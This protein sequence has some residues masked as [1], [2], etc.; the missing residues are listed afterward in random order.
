V[1]RL[2]LLEVNVIS[3]RLLFVIVTLLVSLPVLAQ[4]ETI[5]IGIVDADR[6]VRESVEMQKVYKDMQ[7]LVDKKQNELQKKQEE[8]AQM[9]DKYKTQASVLSGDARAQLEE[10]IRKGYT[11]LDKFREDSKIE[12]QTKESAA[13][14]EMEKKV[15]PIIGEIGKAGNYTLIFRKEAV[16]YM[17]TAIDITDQ[18][19]KILNDAIAAPAPKKSAP[20]TPP[21]VNK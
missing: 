16:V 9:E 15:A 6:I 21:P 13:L 14:S 7:A 1:Q 18:I 2:C 4:T 20:A 11:D 5:K 17:N 19:V 8:I 10:K 12:I 3:K